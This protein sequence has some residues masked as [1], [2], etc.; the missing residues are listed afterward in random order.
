MQLEARAGL[1]RFVWG[2]LDRFV[3]N[4]RCTHRA[5]LAE[6]SSSPTLPVGVTAQQEV[7]VEKEDDRPMARRPQVDEAEVA[8][9]KTA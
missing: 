4:H 8:F 5:W 7:K 6:R 1:D 9:P 2:V 3:T